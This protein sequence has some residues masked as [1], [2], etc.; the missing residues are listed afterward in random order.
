M[1]I[2]D[3]LMAVFQIQDNATRPI[4]A[5]TSEIEKAEE[6]IRQTREQMQKF[7]E[8]GKLAD[9]AKEMEKLGKQQKTISELKSL[10]SQIGMLPKEASLAGRAFQAAGKAFDISKI[11]AGGV[12][13]GIASLRSFAGTIQQYGGQIA[14]VGQKAEQARISL[15]GILSGQGLSA[16]FNSGL[17]D[18]DAALEK[19]RKDADALPGSAQE[20]QEAFQTAASAI[21]TAKLPLNDYIEFVDKATAAGK[22]F[23][24]DAAQSGRDIALLVEGRAGMDVGLWS[25]LAPYMGMSV[26]QAEKFNKLKPEE[27]MEKLLSVVGK[28]AKDPGKLGDMIAAYGDTWDAITSTIT[29]FKDNLFKLGTAPIFKLMKTWAKDTGAWLSSHEKQLNDLVTLVGTGLADAFAKVGEALSGVSVWMDK[30]ASSPFMG[31]V[32]KSLTSAAGSISEAAGGSFG[33]EK[34]RAGTAGVLIG[35][36]LAMSIAAP[37]AAALGVGIAPVTASLILVAGGLEAFLE[38]TTAVAETSGSLAG[39]VTSLASVIG[40]TRDAFGAVAVILG[41]LFAA[42]LPSVVEAF[43]SVVG[44]ITSVWNAVMAVLVPILEIAR[45]IMAIIFAVTEAVLRIV[46]F[47]MKVFMAPLKV[48]SS[49]FLVV[50]KLLNKYIVPVFQ[51]LYEIISTFI[52]DLMGWMSDLGWSFDTAI[53]G[54]SGGIERFLDILPTATE[55]ADEQTAMMGGADAIAEAVKAVEGETFTYKTPGEKPTTVNDFRGST[56]NVQ[57]RFAEGFDADRVS[58]AFVDDLV[59]LGE[60][61][62]QSGLATPFAVR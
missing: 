28:G 12:S 61:R 8:V 57:Q 58:V 36:G 62:V 3:K 11:V 5:I 25:K 10:Q 31:E 21:G 29:S 60:R 50:G 38:H 35:G 51:F 19:I 46:V 45:P 7:A 33:S 43:D 55:K 49:V 52:S 2:I 34:G 6:A 9:A 47:I 48:M 18:A 37:I 42:V 59:K 1:A 56:I 14:D 30:I 22:I 27:R 15:A 26:A 54:L 16:D 17:K 4:K 13:Q 40:P 32:I 39:I 23:G 53:S 20:F 24:Q 44:T 41:D